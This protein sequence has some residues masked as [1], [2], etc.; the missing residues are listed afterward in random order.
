MLS[1]IM[2]RFYILTDK[3]MRNPNIKEQVK[4]LLSRMTPPEIADLLWE[5]WEN[6]DEEFDIY[7]YFDFNKKR[8]YQIRYELNRIYW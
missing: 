1:V 3:K 2:I 4:E 8:A 6:K 7:W 5:M